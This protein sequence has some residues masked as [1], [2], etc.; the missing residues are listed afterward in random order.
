MSTEAQILLLHPEFLPF[1]RLRGNKTTLEGRRKA[2][3]LAIAVQA[4]L[5]SPVKA[6]FLA[7]AIVRQLETYVSQGQNYQKARTWDVA[8]E[9]SPLSCATPD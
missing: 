2:R 9:D 8:M 4:I 7:D 5:V 3:Y 1:L 6:V